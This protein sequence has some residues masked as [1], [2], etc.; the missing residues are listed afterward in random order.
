MFTSSKKKKKT[1]NLAFPRRMVVQWRQRNVQKSVMYEQTFCFANLN[2]LLF[3]RSRWRCRHRCL[4]SLLSF[5]D[6][7]QISSLLGSPSCCCRGFCCYNNYLF[8]YFSFTGL[9]FYVDLRRHLSGDNAKM[10]MALPRNKSSYCLTFY[11]YMYG[12]GMETLNV[13]S[14]NNKIFTKSGNQGSYWKRAIRTVYLSDMVN[15]ETDHV[16]N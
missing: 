7:N 15:V 14:G 2:L 9:Y 6:A 13:F 4:S 12:S 5:P 1:W 11:Y 8:I 16:E 3:Y 10:T